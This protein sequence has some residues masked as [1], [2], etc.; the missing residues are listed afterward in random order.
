[1][2]KAGDILVP[3]DDRFPR[4]S[5]TTFIQEIDRIADYMT[6]SDR[7]GF[8]SLMALFAILP[9]WLVA[10]ILHLSEASEKLPAFL[11]TPMRLINIGVKGV[12][13]TLYYSDVGP[14]PRIF[15]IIEWDAKAG[16][17]PEMPPTD[18]AR[19]Y[20]RAGK[21]APILRKMSVQ[22]RLAFVS[23][24]KGVI[25]GRQEW[26]V[27]E[28]QRATSKS[29]SDALI[30]E[31][32]SVLDHLEYLEKHAAR[33]LSDRKAPTPKALMGK[34]SSVWFEPL[35]PV[36]VISPWNY[37]FYQ[38]IDPCTSAF[39][40]GNPVIYK[41]SEHTPLT[42]VVETLLGEAGFSPSWIQVAYGD[43]ALGSDLVE[44]R[45]RKIF[46]TGSTRTGRK[47]LEQASKHLIPVELELGGKDPMI[48]FEDAN[49]TR[50]AAGALWGALT[51]TGQS[52][53]SI[54]RVYVQERIFDAFRDELL[55][56]ASRVRQKVDQDGSADIG[57]MTTE[58]QIRIV[59]DHLEDAL[60]RGAR[61]LTGQS[62][63]RTS[64]LIPPLVLE[65]VTPEMKIVREETFGPVIPLMPFRDEEE[66]VRLA[67]DSEFGLSAS[68]W[69][70]DLRRAQRVAR[71]IETGNVSINNVMLTEGNHALPFGGTKNSGF[72]RY[73][74]EFGLSSFSN[75]K[76]VILDKDS[77]KI[78]ANWYPY[79]PEKYGLFS[80]LTEATY[81]RGLGALARF[82]LTG[83][84]LE[85]YSARAARMPLPGGDSDDSSPS[86]ESA[87]R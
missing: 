37:P 20:D 70:R 71:A 83:L 11:R 35:G 59:A 74:G 47:I 57:A 34:K 64:S 38:A 44:G 10:G 82:A 50:A 28:I 48:V 61:L 46:F 5:R 86:R 45:P 81:S 51:N 27:S 36:L 65:N 80:R 39:V 55:R 25:L 19:L 6:D 87:R 18:V 4:F 41:P 60:A 77:K 85:G 72:G 40:C 12:V 52:C 79:T 9:R 32:F 42:G 63:D 31:I 2:I 75:I 1:M 13:L 21:A 26:I 62:W 49:L 14:E 16:P 68:V 53:T 84:R 58:T 56:Q 24:L 3:G 17:A 8:K 54:E 33:A 66:A 43:G 23:A 7:E 76:S 29:R 73:K 30:S 78:E 22:E 67:N 69:S 15:P